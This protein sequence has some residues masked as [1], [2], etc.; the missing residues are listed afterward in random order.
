[1]CCYHHLIYITYHALSITILPA[2][3]EIELEI[4]AVDNVN[5]AG[6]RSPKSVNTSIEGFVRMDLNGNASVLA[7]NRHCNINHQENSHFFYSAE[8]V[9]RDYQEINSIPS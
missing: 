9:C 5:V 4:V 2:H 6:F 3:G 8:N 1:M 7:V